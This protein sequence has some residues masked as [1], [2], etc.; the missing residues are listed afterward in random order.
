MGGGRI[1]LQGAAH[2]EFTRRSRQGRATFNYYISTDFNNTNYFQF[3]AIITTESQ[4]R[5][6]C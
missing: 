4:L 3:I 2:L 1:S 6:N 5:G